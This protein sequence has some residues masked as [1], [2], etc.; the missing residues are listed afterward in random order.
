MIGPGCEWLGSFPD[1]AVYFPIFAS[2]FAVRTSLEKGENSN[3]VI[4]KLYTRVPWS[5]KKSSDRSSKFQ[6][7]LKGGERPIAVRTGKWD[8]VE[9]IDNCF[10]VGC[11]NIFLHRMRLYFC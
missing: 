7:R 1:L 11:S 3:R 9:L 8:S 10:S 5:K 6:G 4:I 2:Y